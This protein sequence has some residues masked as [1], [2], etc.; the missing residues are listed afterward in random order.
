MRRSRQIRWPRRAFLRRCLAMPATLALTACVGQSASNVTSETAGPAQPTG[1]SPTQAAAVPPQT[2]LL[3]EVPTNMAQP[4]ALQPTPECGDDDPTP[5]QTEGPFYTPKTPKRTSLIETGMPGTKLVL[6]GYVLTTSCTPVAN[7]LLD[8]WQADDT[9]AYDNVGYTLRGHQ[10]TDEQGR[11]LL[12]TIVPG[13]YPGRTRHIHVRVQAPNQPILTTQL[14]FP[15]EP[16]NDSDSIFH[17]DLLVT[18]QNNDDG[19]AATFNFVLN[20]A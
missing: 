20:I 17:P 11:Y 15:D 9:G 8:F 6:K 5:P 19:K 10:F 7:A 4:Q 12:E 16:G 18:M 13:L 1:L 14:Y 2:P 3:E